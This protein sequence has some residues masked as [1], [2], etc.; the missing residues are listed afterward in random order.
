MKRSLLLAA[1]HVVLALSVTAKFAY[2][3]Q[4]LPHTWVRAEA[5]DPSLPIR[6]RYVRLQLR[7]DTEA[8]RVPVV[9][10]IP[11]NVPDPSRRP[12]GEELWVEVSIPKRGTPRPIQ[13]G[14]KRDGILTPL[15][16]R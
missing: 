2:D 1:I 5:Y 12:A 8:L 14:V 3:R 16:L 13:L 11:P 10:F 4:T 7:G 6:G 15:D 9:F